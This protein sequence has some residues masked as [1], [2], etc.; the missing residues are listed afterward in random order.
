MT[1]GTEPG[2]VLDVLLGLVLLGYAVSGVRQGAVVGVLSLAGFV[3]G[4]VVGTLV[5]PELLGGWQPGLGRT[6]VVLLGV[7]A[8][9]WALQI[10]GVAVGRRLRGGLTWRPA[11]VLDSLL[12]GV[13]AV[14][15][16]ALVSWL[17]A[18]ALRASPSPTLSR[19]IA[20]STVLS[21][22]D[23]L[24]PQDAGR[25]FADFRRIVEVEAFPRVFAGMDPE[26][27]LPVEE[28]DAEVADPV[29]AAAAGSIVKVTGVAEEC[30]RGQEGTGWVSAPQRVVTNA[31]VVAGVDSPLVQVTGTGPELPA[32]VVA[33][34]PE[35]DLAVLAVPGLDAP[36]LPVGEDLARGDDAVVAGFPLDGPY[37]YSPARVRQVLEARGEDIYGTPGVVREVYSLYARVEPGNS[38]GPLLDERAA[39]VGVVFARSLDDAS[40]GYALTLAESAPVL[41]AAPGLQDAVDTGPCAIG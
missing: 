41:A 6:L 9:A 16:V 38:G 22:V 23:D 18:G 33:F 4:A 35:R 39:V 2:V 11:R 8:C 26:Q 30:A 3:G 24:V 14:V 27:I 17:L 36:P 34:D 25:L 15:A 31:H 21:T 32:R 12:G 19:A 1:G 28:P 29:A 40:T 7:L 37:Q 13:A 10:A 5:V 20:G